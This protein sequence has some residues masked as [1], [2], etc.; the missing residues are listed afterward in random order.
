MPVCQSCNKEWT[1]KQSITNLRNICPYCG[2][3]QFLTE[4]SRRWNGISTLIPIIFIFFF[5]LIIDMSITTVF[6]VALIVSFV[7]IAIQPLF[8]EL[9]N[10]KKPVGR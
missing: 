5:N 9:S 4:Q 1:W 7:T 2:T 10:E 8:M 6:I 3:K